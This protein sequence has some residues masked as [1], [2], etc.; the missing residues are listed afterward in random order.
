MGNAA[1]TGKQ[2]KD[3][4]K[5]DTIV[6]IVFL[7]VVVIGILLALLYSS[8]ILENLTA[9]AG[10][11]KV[12]SRTGKV[13][14]GITE[15][16]PDEITENPD[17]AVP[18]YE[19]L[20]LAAGKK[21]QTVYLNNPEGNTCYFVMSLILEDK[22]V[23]WKSDYLEPGMAFDRIEL[24]QALE[25]GSYANVTLQYDCY[26]IADKRE[27]NGSAVTVTLEVK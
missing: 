11:R 8:G 4:R 10:D 9:P 14:T 1:S 17:I 12:D 7:S 16:N 6:S 21:R 26:S 20:E 18:G 5:Q 2:R 22:T 27:L 13:V 15:Y 23:I 24:S 25:K 19:K 3:T